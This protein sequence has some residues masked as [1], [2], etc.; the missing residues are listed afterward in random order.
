MRR[1][2]YCIMSNIVIGI[3]GYV[4]AGKTS[5][6][7]ELLHKI[8]NSILLH[9]G[10]L[11]RA[12]VYSLLQQGKDIKT[13][14]K[15]MKQIDIKQVMEGIG[16]QIKLKD[17]E[18][19]VYIKGE[20]VKEQELQNVQ[21]SLAVSAISQVADNTQLY[22]FAR[23]LIDQFK[24]Q[25]HVI[26]SGRDLMGIYPNLD[27][28]I[29]ITA[30]LQERVRRKCIQYNGQIESEIVKQTIQQRDEMQEK[31]GYYKQY[32]NTITVD[33]TDCKTVQDSTEKVLQYIKVPIAM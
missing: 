6:C 12:I 14:K 21:S 33:V 17:R 8:P 3:E 7:R 31:S 18:T 32:P 15:E 10:N 13:L 29:L 11:Y 28:H 16:I 9:G 25:N 22:E 20:E 5:I 26:C 4:G 27:Y 30:S 2:D 1:K 19:V 24:Q 23:H